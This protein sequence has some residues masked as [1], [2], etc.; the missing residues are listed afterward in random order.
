[1][2]L[3]HVALSLAAAGMLSTQAYATEAQVEVT[4]QPAQHITFTEAD[5]RAMFE[6]SEKRMQ[7]AALSPQEMKETE[8]AWWFVYYYAPV[9]TSLAWSAYQ[10]VPY[11]PA[12]HI[13]NAANYW[14]NSW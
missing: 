6:T 9:V 11:M 10:T 12:Y 2:K 7:L 13:Y 5:V 14:W 1:M 3:K 4:I 8:G